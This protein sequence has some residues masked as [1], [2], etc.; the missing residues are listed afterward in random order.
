MRTGVERESGLVD[1]RRPVEQ[2]ELEGKLS[3]SMDRTLDVEGSI[4]RPPCFCMK[5]NLGDGTTQRFEVREF[6]QA[7]RRDEI[8]R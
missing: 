4:I 1:A 8:P 6:C 3:D 5:S 7:Q 2:C